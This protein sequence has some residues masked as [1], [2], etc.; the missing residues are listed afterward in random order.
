M[1]VEELRKFLDRHGLSQRELSELIGV[2]KPAVDHWL[3][4]RRDVPKPMAKLIRYFDRE[5][6]AMARY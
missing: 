2:T 6:A 5:P 4:G 3:S 1:R